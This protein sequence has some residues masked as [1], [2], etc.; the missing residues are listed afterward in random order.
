MVKLG[1]L[2][3]FDT[4]DPAFHLASLE[5]AWRELDGSQ[6]SPL[7]FLRRL[8]PCVLLGASQEIRQAADVNY[9]RDHK[10]PIVRRPSEG[11]TIYADD[12]CLLY[13][14]VVSGGGA[15]AMLQGLR[16][17]IVEILAG[18][19]L[20][21]AAKPP[22]DILINGRKVAGLTATQWYSVWSFSGTL[23]LDTDPIRLDAIIGPGTAAK[24]VG[25]N[26]SVPAKL[27][28]DELAGRMI[29]RIESLV[30]APFPTAGLTE[31]ERRLASELISVKYGNEKW[32][33]IK[34]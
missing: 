20:S 10:I 7:L 32:N 29:D 15:E 8:K 26:Q 14:L 11:G 18:L 19:G 21:P 1:R 3:K 2:I 34:G 31:K 12:N 17:S 16:D 25:I 23:L 13:S 22:N 4:Q 5:A 24:L 30:D 9:C 33:R 27:T 28:M 6:G